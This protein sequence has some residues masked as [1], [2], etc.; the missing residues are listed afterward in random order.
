MDAIAVGCGNSRATPVPLLSNVLNLE[1]VTISDSHKMQGRL[2]VD[3][4]DGSSSTYRQVT[5]Y[6]RG[7]GYRWSMG[8]CAGEIKTTAQ[9]S[10]K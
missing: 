2:R 1:N 3:C 6:R 10:G 7:S 8:F 5:K 9:L 4:D